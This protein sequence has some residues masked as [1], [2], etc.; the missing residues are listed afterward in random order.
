[1][2]S[3]F[4]RGA[5]NRSQTLSPTTQLSLIGRLGASAAA[6]NRS[7]FG[8]AYCTW[9]R[10]MMGTPGGISSNLSDVLAVASLLLVAIAQGTPASVR[11]LSNASAPGRGLTSE[12]RL[13]YTYL[14]RSYRRSA[15]ATP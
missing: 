11:S 6:R 10:V 9:S 7:G 5:G 4:G 15:H 14:R 13:R 2:P 8:F 3:A 1:M 12:I